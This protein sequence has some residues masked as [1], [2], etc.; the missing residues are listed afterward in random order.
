[1]ADNDAVCVI[2]QDVMQH[3]EDLCMAMLCG[4]TYHDHC[5][6]TYAMVK[7]KS[8]AELRCPQCGMNAADCMRLSPEDP[9]AID[10]TIVIEETV[11]DIAEPVIAETGTAE[12]DIAEPVIAET[13]TANSAPASPSAAAK[14]K[15]KAKGKAKG[16][17]IKGK[18]K[19]KSKSKGKA[20]ATTAARSDGAVLGAD[21]EGGA[22]IGAEAAGG[23]GAGVGDV[24]NGQP[25]PVDGVGAVPGVA[26]GS[27]SGAG[28]ASGA[29]PGA[30]V[31]SGSGSGAGVAETPLVVS[32]TQGGPPSNRP[33]GLLGAGVANGCAHTEAKSQLFQGNVLC[34]YCGRFEYFKLCKA[35]SKVKGTWKCGSCNT[36]H[37]QLFRAFGQ[38]PIPGFQQLS[39]QSKKDFMLSVHGTSGSE[40]AAIASELIETFKIDQEYYNDGGEFLPLS[41]WQTRGY[42]AAMIEANT[43]ERDRRTCSILGKTF[44][45]K[46]L[47][48]G[49]SGS[50][51]SKRASAC[52][53]PK[54]VVDQLVVPPPAKEE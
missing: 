7:Q 27:G 54:S 8:R 24:P 46:I 2:C 41:V 35:V 31:A 20:R 3:E 52:S 22:V 45:V 42:D 21:A 40:A 10:D 28:V 11:P 30:G 32:G 9:I 5:V 29:M 51:G 34:Q 17:A 18:C 39:D 47:S 50:Q 53:V 33:L 12:P 1:M 38:W 4:H 19:A 14:A 25:D 36:K 23:A 6:T 49:N 15:A 44:R 16:K 43:P 48:T 37:T 13:G 26:S